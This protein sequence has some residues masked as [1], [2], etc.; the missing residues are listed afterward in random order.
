M[1]IGCD[2][3][4][5]KPAVAAVV[6]SSDFLREGNTMV[7]RYGNLRYRRMRLLLLLLLLLKLM[8]VV[9][10]M[11]MMQCSAIYQMSDDHFT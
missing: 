9:V 10:V 8:V 4:E 11:A 7:D 2:G 1:P 5:I 6:S 3:R